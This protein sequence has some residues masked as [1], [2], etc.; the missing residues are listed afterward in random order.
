MTTLA[1][2]SAEA[3]SFPSIAVDVPDDWSST[4]Y[5]GAVL[6]A[7]APRPEGRFSPNFLVTVTRHET[8]YGLAD[9]LVLLERELA[10]LPEA[11]VRDSGLSTDVSAAKAVAF[12]DPEVGTLVQVHVIAVVQ[13]QPCV[14]V[15]H[16]TASCAADDL[17]ADEPVLDAIISSLVIA[18]DPVPA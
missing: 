5:P 16:L 15:V 10:L 8:G 17:P 9:A 13:Q 6:A 14:D 3:P 12:T 18:T 4:P 11:S 1:F 7:V 2:P